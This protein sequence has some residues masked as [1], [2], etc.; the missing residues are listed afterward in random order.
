[1]PND[2]ASFF[3]SAI[4]LFRATAEKTACTLKPDQA[5]LFVHL[6]NDAIDIVGAALN[7]YPRDALAASLVWF[8][9]T[10]LIPQLFGMGFD[11]Y[12][13]RY[14][15]VGRELRFA[16]ESIFRAF[17]AD[18]YLAIN[19]GADDP[20]GPSLDEKNAWLDGRRLDW[21]TVI[22][23]ELR[24]LLQAWTETDRIN[25]FHPIWKRLCAVSHP[26]SDWR[27]SGV[28]ESNRHLWFRFDEELAREL[29][30]DASEVFSLIW[31]AVLGCF[32]AAI[33]ALLADA[34]TFCG[35]P[36]LRAVLESVCQSDYAGQV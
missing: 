3:D 10:Q 34:N 19:P 13:G 5:A 7:A 27:L 11:F 25:R 32:P 12:C 29:L 14:A 22:R 36:Q 2:H 24:H 35:C 16:W 8:D 28:G 9:F 20:P 30:A 15:E 21:N 33:P 26:S 18:Q 31:L 1:V 17:H 23:P 4:E 6:S